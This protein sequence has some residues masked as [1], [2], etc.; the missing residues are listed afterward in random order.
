MALALAVLG[1]VAVAL[2]ALL[3][4]VL[5]VPLSLRARGGVH[6]ETADGAIDVRWGGGVV[7]LTAGSG[8]SGRLR[9]FGW[10]VW[11]VGARPARAGKPRTGESRGEGAS[12]WRR[13]AAAWT[14]RRT[15]WPAFRRLLGTLHLRG[16]VAGTVGLADPADTAALYGLLATLDRGNERLALDVDCDWM[17]ETVEL[18]GTVRGLLWPLHAATVG[19]ALWAR[20]DVRRALRAMR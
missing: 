14:H 15:L 2:G 5:L 1:W 13:F 3:L 12:G 20:R 16:R 9:V 17:D 6:G 10:P 19:L 8:G 18:D 4:L 11:R 7:R